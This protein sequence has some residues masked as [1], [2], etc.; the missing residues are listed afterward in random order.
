MGESMVREADG[1]TKMIFASDAQ[2]G[3]NV[4]V[5]ALTSGVQAAWGFLRETVQRA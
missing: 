1:F 5:L 4:V 2:K 3:Q